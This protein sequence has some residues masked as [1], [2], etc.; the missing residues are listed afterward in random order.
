MEN[1]I[2]TLNNYGLE[3]ALV[4]VDMNANR[5]LRKDYV[6]ERVAL[7]LCY[8]DAVRHLIGDPRLLAAIA[9]AERQTI[10]GKAS[11]TSSVWWKE[12]S[13][14]C[15]ELVKTADNG[16]VGEQAKIMAAQAVLYTPENS[17]SLLYGT[18]HV[19]NSV[20]NAVHLEA[21]YMNGADAA[22]AQYGYYAEDYDWVVESNKSIK[23]GAEAERFHIHAAQE[24]ELRKMIENIAS[25][26]GYI[27]A[28]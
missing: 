7:R 3:Q 11:Y 23:A 25:G 13:A 28:K 2:K 12:A 8:L 1:I 26:K 4:S 5:E 6:R 22:N 16:A 17:N 21:I 27:R 10:D 19:A 9:V 14:A 18:S 20:A 15:E 24:A